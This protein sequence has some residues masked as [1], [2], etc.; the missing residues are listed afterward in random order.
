MAYS[1]MRRSVKSL[2]IFSLGGMVD[3]TDLKSVF[4]RSIGSSPIALNI[5]KLAFFYLFYNIFF[6]AS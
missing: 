6:I 2:I 5:F 3:T 1:I 4:T